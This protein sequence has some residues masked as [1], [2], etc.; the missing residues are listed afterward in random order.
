MSSAVLIA[1][2]DEHCGGVCPDVEQCRAAQPRRQ[3][4]KIARKSWLLR[5]VSV[6]R[7]AATACSSSL[8]IVA[9]VWITNVVSSA[10]DRTAVGSSVDEPDD[11]PWSN[12]TIVTEDAWDTED[13]PHIFDFPVAKNVSSMASNGTELLSLVL[14]RHSLTNTTDS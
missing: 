6:A 10:K 11:D 1:A 13:A 8:A 9:V 5:V 2:G 7:V 14:L 12:L 4:S 3:R